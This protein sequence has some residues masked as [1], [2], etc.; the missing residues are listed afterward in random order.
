MMHPETAAAPRAAWGALPWD[1]GKSLLAFQVR[2][3][4]GRQGNEVVILIDRDRGPAF[5]PTLFVTCFYEKPGKSA[6][7]REM[8]LRAIGMARAWA[9]TRG[10]DFDHDLRYGPFLSLTDAE[11]L[12]DHLMLSVD[13]QVA[14][15]SVALL[16]KFSLRGVS[17]LEQLRPNPKLLAVVSSGIEPGNALSRIKWVA[18]YAEWHLQQRIAVADR[19]HFDHSDL[20]NFGPQAVA[21]LRERGRGAG[22]RS[23][24]NEALEGV[25][26]EAIDLISEALRP[27]D[28]LNPFE[29][30]FLQARNEL[31]WHVFVSSGGRRSEVQSVLVK[32]VTY[33]QR[34]MFFSTSKT[35]PRTV[36]ISQRAADQFERFIEEY[37]SKLP[38][39]AR[40]R[41]YLFTGKA[42]EHLTPRSVGRVFEAICKRVPGC[43][44][45][46]TPH[47]ARRTWNDRFS[48]RL[49]ALPPEKRMPVEQEMRARNMLQGWSPTSSMGALYANR[50]LRRKADELGEELAN[51]VSKDT[52]EPGND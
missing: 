45:F 13:A 21:R 42:G 46:L 32:D 38:Q 25:P 14:A 19:S 8:V 26:Q 10:R 22:G 6:N 12:A 15:N 9:I 44:E 11:A 20:R 35:R 18:R 51:A 41:G 40:K 23:S 16:G 39:T 28:P 3:F 17:K 48:E 5:Y 33:S 47:T 49:D 50:H 24:D 1:A 52:G 34:R 37:W 27:G 29:P 30:G 2:R 36:P 31:L 4:V 7:T 43:P